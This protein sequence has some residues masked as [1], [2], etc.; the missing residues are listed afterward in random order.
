MT[1]NHSKIK[2]INILPS[3][4]DSR[5]SINAE[6]MTFS[7]VTGKNNWAQRGSKG[8]NRKKQIIC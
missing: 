7:K 1:L 3:R 6:I 4:E 8:E 2:I 5:Y